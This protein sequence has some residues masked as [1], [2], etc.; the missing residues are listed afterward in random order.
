MVAWQSKFNVSKKKDVLIYIII[1]IYKLS[2]YEH[3][4]PL[5]FF[6]IKVNVI[7]IDNPSILNILA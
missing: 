6:V 5:H 1:S 7:N 2:L 3:G 4:L